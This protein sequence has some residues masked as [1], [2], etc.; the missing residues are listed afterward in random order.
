MPVP[1]VLIGGTA[2]GAVLLA[3]LKGRGAQS[4]PPAPEQPQQPQAAPP[5]QASQP[6][7]APPKEDKPEISGGG[8][9]LAAALGAIG[10]AAL[11]G[12]YDERNT[13][14]KAVA[15]IAGA[16]FAVAA[17]AVGTTVAVT[18]LAA[19]AVVVVPAAVLTAAFLSFI[20]QA[21]RDA[22]NA[23]MAADAKP[24][25]ALVTAGRYE[26][27]WAENVRLWEA[28][29]KLYKERSLLPYGWK[30]GLPDRLP[31]S[32]GQM[33]D[34]PGAL[35]AAY[36]ASQAEGD[37]LAD[38]IEAARPYVIRGA[39]HRYR[40][41]DG[42]VHVNPPPQTTAQ[43][44]DGLQA[45]LTPAPAPAPAPAVMAS[46]PAPAPTPVVV[47]PRPLDA[48]A[49]ATV[50]AELDYLQGGRLTTLRSEAQLART[51]QP[52]TAGRSPTGQIL[53]VRRLPEL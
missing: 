1:V 30:G 5:A 35:E 28:K 22:R 47:T 12:V 7:P 46:A 44:V 26:E 29:P 17:Y 33:L 31:L 52:I 51:G 23:E 34:V 14:S 42:T 6:A 20:N 21:E 18:G 48:A 38:L 50:K 40:W 11:Q 39:A 49:Q 3:R 24:I 13:T 15:P 2:L 36:R 43:R 53:Y 16:G 41:P 19:G 9:A 8:V 45:L 37:T 4:A 10:G 32:T 25:K 27:A